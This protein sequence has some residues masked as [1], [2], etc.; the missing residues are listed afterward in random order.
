M[1]TSFML[2]GDTIALSAWFKKKR[3]WCTVETDRG[4]ILM[5]HG[6]AAGLLTIPD[7][8]L[9]RL[10]SQVQQVVCCHPKAV[11][12]VYGK[13]FGTEFM[14][15]L[16]FSSYEGKVLGQYLVGEDQRE[17]LVASAN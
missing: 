14:S 11:G 4:L 3:W 7:M 1:K 12:E 10:L 16:L 8:E 5:V 13:L 17:W 6:S 15:K 9:D 2:T